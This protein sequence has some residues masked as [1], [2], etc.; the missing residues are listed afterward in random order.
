VHP[1]ADKLN[2]MCS[3]VSV[4]IVREHGE[5]SRQ[6][7]IRVWPAAIALAPITG[8]CVEC[9]DPNLGHRII[10]HAFDRPQPI[11]VGNMVED[12]AALG[13]DAWVA[14]TQPRCQRQLGAR[15]ERDQTAPGGK[16]AVYVAQQIDQ[17]DRLK[18]RGISVGDHTR[19]PLAK[20]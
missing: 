4:F 8:E 3:D 1:H 2:G 6:D 12:S 11:G 19:P 9:L 13:P 14:V 20:A 7:A 18:S 17:F 5:R 15:S 10:E 16:A